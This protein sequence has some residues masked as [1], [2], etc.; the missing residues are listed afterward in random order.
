M[1]SIAF[2][3]KDIT[4]IND[5]TAALTYEM[6]KISF[7]EVYDVNKIHLDELDKRRINNNISKV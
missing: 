4:N 6:P 1:L 5:L 3:L 2:I 7:G